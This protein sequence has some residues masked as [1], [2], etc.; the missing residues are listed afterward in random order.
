M[1]VQRTDIILYNNKTY[2]LLSLPLDQYF[3]KYQGQIK[4]YGSRT[5]LYRGYYADW[6]IE[7]DQLFLIDFWGEDARLNLEYD[8]SDLFP[9]QKKVLAKWFTGN[10]KIPMGKPVRSFYGGLGGFTY[11][12]ELTFVINE[13]NVIDGRFEDTELD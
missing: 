9:N 2:N 11:E 7:H 12:H 13:G 8:L 3:E 6:L 1:T 10:I 4:P 5:S